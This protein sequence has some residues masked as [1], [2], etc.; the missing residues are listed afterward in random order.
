MPM[1]G[2]VGSQV[3]IVIG[4]ENIEE[5][6]QFYFSDP[7]L[8]AT[9]KLNANG[10]PEPNKY[11]VTIAPDCPPGT[12]EA[13]VMT[14]FGISSARA[15]TV[16]TLPEVTQKN[17]NTSLATAME[18]KTNTVCNSVMSPKSV[19][20]YVFEATEG[21]RYFIDCSAKGIDSK[22]DAVL[23]VAD[24]EGRD[25]LVERKGGIID[26]K[27]PRRG[28]FVVKVHELTFKGGVEYYYRLTVREAA[29]DAVIPIPL[30][31]KTVS[32]FSWPPVGLT[33]SAAVSETEPNN[34]QAQAQSIELPCDIAGAFFP[35]A[36]VDTFQF[37]AKAG[38][39]WW[40]EL[41][42][43]RLG[44]PTD[45]SILIQR[46]TG[47]GNDQKLADI[48]EFT[49][50]P[51][52]VKVSSNGYAYDGPPFDA[53]S[54]DIIG[55]LEIKEEGL[56]RLQVTDLFGG[57]RNDP[58]NIYRLVIRQAAPDFA[59][60][61]WP[62][63][64]ELRNGDRNALSKPIALRGGA[65]MA[66]EV[67][68]VRR[69]GFDGDVDLVME[70]L[71]DGVT[72]QGLKIPAGQSRGIMLITAHQDAP[73][74]FAN[75]RFFGRAQIQGNTVSRPCH[76]AEFKWPIPDSWGEVPEPRLVADVPVSVCGAEYAPLTITAKE[77]KIW[78]VKPGDK[79]TIPL[80]HVRRSEFSGSN[81]LLKTFG[82]VFERTPQFSVVLTDDQSEAILDTGA[83]KPPPGDYVI[84]FYGG[85][86][87]KYRHRMDTVVKAQADFK[88]AEQEI[89][90]LATEVQRLK[91]EAA[92]ASPDRQTEVDD[93]LA[94][95][96]SEQLAANAARKS[97]EEQV[98]IATERSQPRD[99]VDIVVTEPITIRVLPPEVK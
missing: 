13:R 23:V 29:S 45:A 14:H 71:P 61:A 64:M 28:K 99:I 6:D 63:H 91:D 31:S 85:A 77:N 53:G 35:A 73:R 5:A 57:T 40:V 54:P 34:L 83:L 36:D 3:D 89:A 84:A 46:V 78:E 87:A 52:P 7:R 76:M 56:Y 93:T 18:F 90:T 66:L 32:A 86:V 15:F 26:F 2:T 95:V 67:V 49:D 48:A 10:K 65:T 74:S 8:S 30:R 79:L 27:A 38:E 60:V 4:G 69:D 80:V 1:G 17:P 50:I 16:G 43:E 62:L 96:V 58:R 47:E 88:K 82:N 75:V 19:D 51:S 24:A 25:L 33:E 37:N 41:A 42:S 12:Y 70:G 81:L 11:I 98:K 55:K 22:L 39:I 44:L 59:L 72:A 9:P 94:K 21:Q 92:S 97:A 20:Y 68:T